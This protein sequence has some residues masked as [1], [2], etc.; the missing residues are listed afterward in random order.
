MI[1]AEHTLPLPVILVGGGGHAKVLASTLLLLHRKILGFVD[2]KPSLPPLLGIPHL[3]GD[4]AVFLHP[5]DRVRL[6]NAVGSTGST[7]LRRKIY[8]QFREKK[9]V[10]ETVIHP[11]AIIAP[12]VQAEDGV[13]VMAGAVVQPGSHLGA[14]VI[15]NTGARIDHDCTI[16]AHAHIAPG[17]TL[18]G[19]VEI[20]TGAHVGTGASIIQGIVV[21][22]TSVVGAGAVVVHHV[23]AGVTVTGIPARPVIRPAKPK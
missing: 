21:G 17:A 16:G 8:E 13:Q 20:G 19:Q 3:G 11:A 12:E 4:A 5:P 9:Y 15:I 2:P 10:F 14:D 23:P 18:S 7:A 22:A 6:V 1:D